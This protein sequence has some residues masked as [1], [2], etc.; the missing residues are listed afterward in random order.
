MR[1]PDFAVDRAS[2][3]AAPW[4]QR[5]A[6][7]TGSYDRNIDGVALTLNRL[8]AHL[9]RRGH[10]V[11]VLCPSTRRR[12][13]LRHAGATVVRVP[14]VPLPVWSEYRLTFGLG[15]AARRALHAFAPTVMHVAIQDAMGHAAVRWAS[16]RGIPSVCSHHTRFESY[17]GF[18]GL[19]ALEPLF[20]FGMRRFHARCAATLPP[21]TSLAALLAERGIPR[22]RPWARGVETTAFSPS[23][24]SEA[25]REA[26]PG[27]AGAPVLLLVARL[28]WEKGLRAFASAVHE[29]AEVRALPVRV[30]VIGDG[31]ARRD[32]RALLPPNATMLGHVTGEPLATAYASSDLFLYP[33]TTE[34]WGATCLEAQARATHPSPQPN[35]PPRFRLLTRL[36]LAHACHQRPHFPI[37]R[38]RAG[39]GPPR[40]RCRRTG[41][42]G[43]R[44]TRRRRA[45]R[46]SPCQ[47]YVSCRRRR[48]SPCR[49]TFAPLDGRSWRPQRCH[50]YL[51]VERRPDALRVRYPPGPTP[52]SPHLI[53][54]A[55]GAGTRATR[56]PCRCARLPARPPRMHPL[57]SPV[58]L[59]MNWSRLSSVAGGRLPQAGTGCARRWDGR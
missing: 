30:V 27:P 1:I 16:E 50:I 24:R 13:V 5:V 47:R 10:E 51:G 2:V 48:V 20:W 45:S 4:Q 12:P 40:G 23:K 44:H 9:L 15:R 32:L 3:A 35:L 25:W 33:S 29:I 22:V 7:V 52:N 58:L 43:C 37:A 42:H 21:S 6:L 57:S 34:G 17:L 38:A 55:C 41:H 59:T 8:V 31:P 18:Y 19:S 49:P 46:G 14:S 54:L 56:S 26:L 28:R 39:V 53:S 11:L 36:G